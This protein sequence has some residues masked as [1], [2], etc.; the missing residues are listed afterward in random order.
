MKT[1]FQLSIYNINETFLFSFIYMTDKTL[2]KAF[3]EYVRFY[4]I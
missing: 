4:F 1:I 3:I 2:L